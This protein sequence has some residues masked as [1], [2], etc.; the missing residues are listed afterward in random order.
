[1][2]LIILLL[3][4][5]LQA[6]FNVHSKIHRPHLF[7]RYVESMKPLLS[8][9]RMSHGW[10]AVIGIL[11]PI[12][13]VVGILNIF[14]GF[15]WLLYLL[16]GIF[17]LLYC[18]DTEDLKFGLSGYFT[19]YANDQIDKARQE[20]SKFL[21][22]SVPEDKAALNRAVIGGIFLKSQTNIFS[23]IFWFAVLGPFGAVLYYAIAAINRCAE[24]GDFGLLDTL[25]TSSWLKNL[26]DWIP[27]RLVTLTYALIGHFGPV[28]NIWLKRL[29]TGLSENKALTVDSGLKALDLN[30]DT[31]PGYS[32]LATNYQALSLVTRALW[33]WVIFSALLLASAWF[34]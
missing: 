9:L 3:S 4:L 8:K 23:L 14:F 28:F 32:D 30:L 33:T 31:D 24:R 7:D 12:I 29:A 10:T 21:G 22:D 27:V 2:K 11:L 6:C 25:T 15:F 17:V 26:L 19:A 1:M 34:F 20:A 5:I 18:M 13:V 16:F